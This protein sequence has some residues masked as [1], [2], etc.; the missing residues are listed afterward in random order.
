ML[1]LFL[2]S[3]PKTALAQLFRDADAKV[4]ATAKELE[5]PPDSFQDIRQFRPPRSRVTVLALP[6]LLVV[7]VE[8]VIVAMAIASVLSSYDYNRTK[9]Q[10]AADGSDVKRV[11]NNEAI[12]INEYFLNH[13]P[14]L[15]DYQGAYTT[16]LAMLVI[17]IIIK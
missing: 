17:N 9:A 14:L 2:S 10:L 13:N 3:L 16:S 8:T 7:L 4:Q 11:Y 15:F 6:I 5:I 1:M 12:L